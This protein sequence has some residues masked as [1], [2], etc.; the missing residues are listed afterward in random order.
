MFSTACVTIRESVYGVRCSTEVKP[1]GTHFSTGSGFAI[2]PGMVITAGH[3]AHIEND[4]KKPAHKNFD[5]I[6]SPDIG[7]QM[8]H[9][10]LIAEDPKNDIALQLCRNHPF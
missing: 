4:A 9:A 10:V 7:Q 3:L 5:V 8:E 1:K 2:A 6:R